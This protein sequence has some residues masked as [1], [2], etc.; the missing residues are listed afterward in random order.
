[1]ND[2][3]NICLKCGLCC[4]GSLIGFVEIEP[5]EVNQLKEILDI[6]KSIDGG[7]F[8]QPCSKYCVGCSIY[9]QRPKQCA[10]FKCGLLES[11]EKKEIQFDM[12]IQTIQEI[13]DIKESIK[14]SLTLLKIDLQ[15]KSFYFKMIELE[16]KLKSTSVQL[17]GSSTNQ[18]L[19]FEIYNLEKLLKAKMDIP[20]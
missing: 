2:P 14:Q 1:M 20:Q 12:A 10:S 19:L 3:G 13:K 16:K 17:E 4:D 6:E 11:L 15:S 5:E 7:I 8:L 18:N 9:S